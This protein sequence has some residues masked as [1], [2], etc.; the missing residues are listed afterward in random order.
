MASISSRS[1]G[2]SRPSF[3]SSERL[4]GASEILDESRGRMDGRIV[5]LMSLVGV[6]DSRPVSIVLNNPADVESESLR[7]VMDSG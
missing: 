4:D 5:E 7:Y 2:L 1:S 6:C 3:I